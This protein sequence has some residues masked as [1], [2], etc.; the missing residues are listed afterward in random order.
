MMA[1]LSPASYNYEESISTLRYAN[2]AKSIKNKP[3]INEDPKDAMLKEYQLEIDRL[4]DALKARQ[5]GHQPTTTRPKPM[6]KISNLGESSQSLAEDDLESLQDLDHETVEQL[7]LE[8]DTERQSLLAS[9][10]IVVEEK[11]RI[12]AEL[13]Q[14]AKDLE[15][16]RKENE[17]LAKKLSN[18]E[19]KL[20]IGGV[21]IVEKISEQEA[22]LVR[23]QEKL[24]IQHER[25]RALQKKL[26]AHQEAQLQ[27]EGSFSSLQEE[28]DVKTRKLKKLWTKM[29]EIKTDIVDIKD[30]F[31]TEKED[32]LDTIR[33]LSKELSLKITI[34]ENFI[35]PEEKLKI[36]QRVTYDEEREEWVLGRPKKVD[37]EHIP[38]LRLTPRGHLCQYAKIMMNM[39]DDNPRYRHENILNTQVF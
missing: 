26:E 8:V 13:E 1:T 15:I 11:L 30:E 24:Q 28:I 37:I 20:L 2:R 16:E 32:L 6:G 7:Q 27:M 39:G 34:I 18:L 14:K 31:R 23:A 29:D 25:E 33:E 35:P 22:E 12:A 21:N 3:T 19:A 17:L 9:K 4:K 38:R 10:D 36:S 5:N